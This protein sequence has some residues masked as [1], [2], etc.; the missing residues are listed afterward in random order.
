[1]A[2]SLIVI[3]SRTLNK[4]RASAHGRVFGRA[5]I[6]PRRLNNRQYLLSERLGGKKKTP[7]SEWFKPV[8]K[9]ICK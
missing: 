4:L 3:C 2:E 6:Q 8:T 9:I 7:A 5:E 1:M